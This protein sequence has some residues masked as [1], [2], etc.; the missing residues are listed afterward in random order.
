MTLSCQAGPRGGRSR[1][2][3]E[4]GGEREKLLVGKRVLVMGACCG[5]GRARCGGDAASENERL[6]AVFAGSPQVTAENWLWAA[7]WRTGWAGQMG[8][9]GGAHGEG[10]DA[11]TPEAT[12]QA[13]A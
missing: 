12:G 4:E 13:G 11:P 5:G 9:T 2:R 1:R 7:C 8:A 6:G 10:A 3:V